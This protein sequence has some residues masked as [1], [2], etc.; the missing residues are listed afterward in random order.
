[1]HTGTLDFGHYIAFIRQRKPVDV[2]AFLQQEFIDRQTLS[3]KQ[4]FVKFAK[5]ACTSTL[6][7]G[8]QNYADASDVWYEVSDEEVRKCPKDKEYFQSAYLLFYERVQ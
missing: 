3:E 4:E 6:P 7:T 8:Q 1:V 2:S 5:R